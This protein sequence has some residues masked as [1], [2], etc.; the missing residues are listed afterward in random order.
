MTLEQNRLSFRLL[1]IAIF[2]STL[3]ITAPIGIYFLSLVLPLVLSCLILFAKSKVKKINLITYVILCFCVIAHIV[4]AYSFPRAEQLPLNNLQYLI[5]ISSITVLSIGPL[6]CSNFLNSRTANNLFRLLIIFHSTL[7]LFQFFMWY[8]INIDFDLG[9]LLGGE[10]HRAQTKFGLYRATGVWEEPSI[11]AGYIFSFLTIRYVF[12]QES[13]WV[14]KLGL[15]T[16]ILSFSTLGLMLSCVYILL[17]YARF[18]IS[19]LVGFIAFISVLWVLSGEHAIERYNMLV[20]GSDGSTKTKTYIVESYMQS[21]DII[22]EGYGLVD[23]KK[24]GTYLYD[25]LGDLTLYFNLLIIFGLFGG[26][27]LLIFIIELCKI[28]GYRRKLFVFSLFLKVAAFYYPYFWLLFFLVLFS[29]KKI[30]SD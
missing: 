25:G 13:G 15:V 14:D 6:K 18:R 3:R 20:D 28:Q 12:F 4:N 2:F 11:Y 17:V 21:T 22:I 24:T 29:E 10:A 27:I 5:L 7:F 30:D 26:V 8:I 19:Y 1:S 9:S 16:I 23:K